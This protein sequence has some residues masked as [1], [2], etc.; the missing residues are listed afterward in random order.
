MGIRKAF[1]FDSFLAAASQ[2]ESDRGQKALDALEK[3][4]EAIKEVGHPYD[5]LTQKEG[6]ECMREAI[7]T[8]YDEGYESNSVSSMDDITFL[9]GSYAE[10]AFKRAVKRKKR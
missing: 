6:E 2:F 9:L 8:L 4:A 7:Q 1:K 5:Q 10:E 3:V